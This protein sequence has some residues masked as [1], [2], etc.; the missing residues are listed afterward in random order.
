MADME[1]RDDVVSL[2]KR[3]AK[4]LGEFLNGAPIVPER[5]KIAERMVVAATKVEHMDQI[6][7]QSAVSNGLRLVNMMRDPAAREQY[8]AAMQPR[9]MPALGKPRGMKSISDK[10]KE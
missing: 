10:N 2:G 4:M 3:G 5:V 8:V 6:R 9:I 1:F 7:D